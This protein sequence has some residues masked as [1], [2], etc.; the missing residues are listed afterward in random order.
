MSFGASDVA[1][2]EEQQA[3]ILAGSGAPLGFVVMNTPTLGNSNHSFHIC[4][5]RNTRNSNSD[6]IHN[7]FS[8][9]RARCGFGH[10]GKP[11]EFMTSYV[12][13]SQADLRAPASSHRIRG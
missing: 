12:P 8:R 1:C 6:V 3:E 10:V 11:T 2:P 7:D 9:R 4:H 13:N 5:D